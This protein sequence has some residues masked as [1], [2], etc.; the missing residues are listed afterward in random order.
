MKVD[1]QSSDNII[2]IG[3][4]LKSL[5]VFYLRSIVVTWLL[6]DDLFLN[7]FDQG[8]SGIAFLEIL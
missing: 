1:L 2:T 7:R 6:D 5:I 8:V 3:I 4:L